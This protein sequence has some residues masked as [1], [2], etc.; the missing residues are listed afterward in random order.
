M[1]VRAGIPRPWMVGVAASAAT[2]ATLGFVLVWMYGRRPPDCSD[3]RTLAL[4]Q[5]QLG[6]IFGDGP[7]ARLVRIT[8][9]AGG[10]IALRFAC[11]ANFD[12]DMHL[13]NG[14]VVTTIHYTSMFIPD[15]R[16]QRVTVQAQPLL[17]W[18][19]AK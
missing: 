10:P 1:P 4:V 16:V 19:P 18:F 8:T 7:S 5:Q 9:L 17:A 6:R 14:T 12:K 3:Q 2:L 13:P 15:S 11:A